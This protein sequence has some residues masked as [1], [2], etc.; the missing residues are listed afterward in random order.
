[1]ALGADPARVVLMVVG[2]GVRLD[3]GVA[4]GVVGALLAT[5]APA[6]VVTG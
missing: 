2:G 4:I 6:S 1:M 3:P 5:R